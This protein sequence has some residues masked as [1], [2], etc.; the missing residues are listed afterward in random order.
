[1]V[2]GVWKEERER[3]GGSVWYTGIEPGSHSVSLTLFRPHICSIRLVFGRLIRDHFFRF[4]IIII[5]DRFL[6]VGRGLS[7][8]RRRRVSGGWRQGGE[9]VFF[10]QPTLLSHQPF[11]RVII[12]FLGAPRT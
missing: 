9:F 3:V 7:G 5:D 2:T 8:T 1:M 6:I 10:K 12:E 11:G 4:L